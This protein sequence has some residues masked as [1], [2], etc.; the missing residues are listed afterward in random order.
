MESLVG[1]I[2]IFP[3][4]LTPSGWALCNGQLL[5]ISQ[6]PALFSLIGTTF[7]GNGASNFALPNY[8]NQAPKGSQYFIS[9]EGNFPPR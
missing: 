2:T 4:S 3:F 8:E 9:L 5:P 7:G 1:Q 6:Y